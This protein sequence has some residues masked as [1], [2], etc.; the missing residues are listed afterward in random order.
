MRHDSRLGPTLR[1]LGPVLLLAIGLSPAGSLTAHPADTGQTGPAAAQE[2]AGATVTAELLVSLRRVAQATLDPAGE[3]V[4]YTVR[5]PRAADEAPGGGRSEIW[6]AD[7]Q[8]GEK[9]RYT[10]TG[11]S[12]SSPAFSPDGRWLTF[13]SR[14]EEHSPHTQLWRMSLSGGEAQPLTD[15]DTA[16]GGYRWSPGGSRIAFGATDALTEEERKARDEGRDWQVFDTNFMHRRIWVLDVESGD[17]TVV[18]DDE[19]TA[20][21]FAWTP[22]GK[23]FVFQGADTPRTDDSYMFMDL[24]RVPATGGDPVRVADTDGKL[25]QLAVSPDGETV[26]FLGAVSLNDP[27]AQS[28]FTVP[29]AGGDPRNLTDGFDGSATSIAWLDDG[30]LLMLA[31][32]GTGTTLSRVDAASGARTAVRTEGVVLTSVEARP[33]AGEFVAVAHTPRHPTEVFTGLLEGGE[34]NRLTD[35]NPDLGDVR[36][37]RQE[38]VEWAA[39]D[40]W[41]MQGVLTYPLDF[42]QNTRYPLILQLHGGPEG[43][44]FDGWTSSATYPVQLLAANGYMVLQP[45]YR[46]SAGRGVAFSKADHDDLGGKEFEDVLAGIDA[47]AE[48]GLIDPER[49]GTGGWSYGGYFSAWAA[50]RHSARFKAAVVAAGISNWVS[51]TGTTDIPYEMSLVHWNQWWFENPALH[52]MR[53]PLAHVNDAQTATLVVHGTADA[54][55]H[56]GQGLELYT[57]LRVKEVP[58]ELVFYPRQ[59]HGLVER[60]HQLDFA[61]RV[62]EW[63]DRWVKG[64]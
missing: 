45:N 55:V 24:Y 25:G 41:S 14:R 34:L 48:R 7:L 59:P 50:T 35:S 11:T 3:R 2:S 43:I 60:A 6:I 56:P 40:G 20:Y 51:F 12:A 16:V 5:V 49:V 33:E 27:I 61:Q 39:A 13:L 21:S 18:W 54:R 9:R 23:H 4:A 62:L 57:A 17:T 42:V 37:A 30:T 1:F 36:L 53:S 63:F 38:T 64:S 58:T 8:T 28:L 19:L 52:W 22:D 32:E 29:L 44:S 10:A 46:G 15:H 31:Q 26:G 47:L